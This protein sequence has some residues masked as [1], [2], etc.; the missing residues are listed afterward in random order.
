MTEDDVRTLLRALRDEPVPA[1]SLARVRL[2]A[3]ERTDERTR[4]RCL[5]VG[6]K[7]WGVLAAAAVVVMLAVLFRPVEPSIRPAAGIRNDIQASHVPSPPIVRPKRSEAPATA[8]AKWKDKRRRK[9]A[10]N[11][12]DVIVRIETA[13][14]DVVILLIGD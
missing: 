8:A 3:A 9:A 10:A 1:D 2:A 14:P 7:T 11:A 6:W 5:G 12:E 13:D 4:V